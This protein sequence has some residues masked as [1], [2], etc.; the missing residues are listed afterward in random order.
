MR[1]RSVY[2]LSVSS[3]L[4]PR[5]I[6]KRCMGPCQCFTPD[7]CVRG[8]ISLCVLFPGMH[9]ETIISC[10]RKIITSVK[11]VLWPS[12]VR[13]CLQVKAA[14]FQA[15]GVCVASA[16]APWGKKQS[17]WS[18][19]H[20]TQRGCAPCSSASNTP[21]LVKEV[22]VKDSNKMHWIDGTKGRRSS[23]VFPV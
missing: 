17:L 6:G 22:A 1:Q 19:C 4:Q 21:Q 3:A 23:I 13:R 8:D 5:R 15:A 20:Y 12:S 2:V 11:D 7:N 14:I 10:W 18:S 9:I 16:K